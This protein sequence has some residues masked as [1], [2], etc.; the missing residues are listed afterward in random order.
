MEDFVPPSLRNDKEAFSN[1]FRALY[2]PRRDFSRAQV[3]ELLDWLCQGRSRSADPHHQIYVGSRI[4]AR[5]LAHTRRISNGRHDNAGGMGV[6]H[7]ELDAIVDLAYFDA[8]Q[9]VRGIQK[10]IDYLLHSDPDMATTIKDNDPQLILTAGAMGSAMSHFGQL[11]RSGKQYATHPQESNIVAALAERKAFPNGV[12]E[13][14][15]VNAAILRYIIYAHDEYEDDMSGKP[16]ERNLSPL[17]GNKVHMT[18]LTHYILLQELCGLTEEIADY[19]SDGLFCL[20]K[21]VGYSGRRDWRDYIIELASPAPVAPRGYE[22]T[23]S[24]AKKAEMEHNSR[25]DKN[26]PP[27][28]RQFPRE[29]YRQEKKRYDGRERDYAWASGRLDEYLDL[30]EGYSAEVAKKIHKVS[31]G[32][33]KAYSVCNDIVVRLQPDKLV[34]AYMIA[35]QAA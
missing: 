11:R 23:V 13:K 34:E 31:L 9:T 30:T 26:E 33:F 28:R 21:P 7:A 17:R 2:D 8:T 15:R 10:G 25:I 19:T 24:T 4:L 35:N 16:G 32:E 3:S 5:E 18:P 1:E 6:D 14:F 27:R 22:G 12:P 29:N 20:T